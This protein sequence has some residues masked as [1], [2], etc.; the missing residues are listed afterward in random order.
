MQC[1][2][3]S[4]RHY[5]APCSIRRGTSPPKK[6][7]VIYAINAFLLPL[8]CGYLSLSGVRRTHVCSAAKRGGSLSTA[9]RRN[10]TKRNAMEKQA[11]KQTGF[12]IILPLNMDTQI[13]LSIY[14]QEASGWA[15][16]EEPVKARKDSRGYIVSH[17]VV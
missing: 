2:A 17:A 16:H 11:S 8:V 4:G 5:H 9:Q 10:E 7:N 6:K 14:L 12:V 1:N 15:K 13:H 3:Q